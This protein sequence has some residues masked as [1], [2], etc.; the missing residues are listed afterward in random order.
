MSKLA[1]REAIDGYL[2]ILPWLIGLVLF[3]AGPMLGSLVLAFVDWDLLGTPRWAGLANVQHLMSDRLVGTSLVN[4]AYYTFLSVPLRLALAL[5]VALLLSASARGLSFFR[6]CFYLPAVVPAVANVILWMWLFN[7][8]AGLLNMGLAALGLPKLQWLWDPALSKPSLVLMSLWTTGNVV[9]IFLAGL[10]GIPRGLYEAA[11][12]DGA[13]GWQQFVHVTLPMLSPVILFNLVMGIIYSFQ[14]FTNA[15]LMTQGGP[16]NS[17]LFT[18]LYLY[19]VAFEQ[20]KIGYGS[21]IAWVLFLV[22]FLFTIA[23]WK[24]ADYWV[25]YEGKR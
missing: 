7:P 4:T 1:R 10:Q 13:D 20:F 11:E 14:V 5:G 9:V 15:F 21:A 25:Y 23:Q 2:F 24:L 12:I 22:I 3:T 19:Q 6:T 8:A 16:L 18:V 17:T